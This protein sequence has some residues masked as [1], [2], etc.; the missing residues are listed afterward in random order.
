MEQRKIRKKN[1]SLTEYCDNLK[2]SVSIND[3]IKRKDLKILVAGCGTGKQSIDISFR[4][5]KS[6]IL[7]IDLSKSSLAYAI[8]K[9]KELD[10]KNIN[11]ICM[12]ILNV[13]LLKES[14]DYISC[15]G[16]LH[17]MKDPV[18]GWKKLLKC[19]NKNGLLEIA[20]Y[21]KSAR[22]EILKFRSNYKI[23]KGT[24]NITDLKR[25][26]QKM[27]DDN[28]DVRRTNIINNKDFFSLSGFKDLFVNENE[29][30]YEIS[31]IKKI[32]ND[33][34]LSFCGFQLSNYQTLKLRNE[35]IK[36]LS[37]KQLS[38]IEKKY[39]HFFQGMYQFWCQ[40]H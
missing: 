6:K 17:H 7:A 38:L 25:I 30:Q 16:V 31:E 15:G 3:N 8:R 39:P 5:P 40:K 26:R 22:K 35:K 21:S 2:L 10:I 36:D 13:N 37:L 4:F 23:K 9:T 12:D 32:V 18:L 14:F 1:V 20:L 28:K 29:I 34:D 27:I 33:L 11:Y 19:L 24:F